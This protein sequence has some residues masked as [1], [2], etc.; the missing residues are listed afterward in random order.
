[1]KR[2]DLL[3]A[4]LASAML[5]AC[6]SNKPFETAP[7]PVA[8]TPPPA[9][10]AVIPPRK[11]RI[12]FALGGGAARGFAHVG[13]IKA[14]ETQGIVP[15]VVVGT[16]VGSVVGALYAAGG[17]AFALQKLAFQMEESA[18]TDWS[19]FDRGF[20]KGEALERFINQQ[21][22][23]RPIEQ[24][25]RRFG[26]VA[27]DLGRGEMTVFATGNVGQAVRASSA[28]PGVFGAVTIREREYVDGGLVSPIPVRAA[29]Q[30][31]ADIVIA[32]DISS[33]ASGRRQQ[34]NLDLMID[35]IAIMGRTI[36][37]YELKEADAVVRPDIVGLPVSNF[38]QRHEAIL[39]GEQAAYVALPRIRERIA[40][41][42]KQG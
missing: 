34:G 5:A 39:R 28:I 14:L 25:K 15:D 2:R 11:P 4:G 23:N 6:A 17:D 20:I 31:G 40:A 26:A 19:V 18:L 24:L 12:G 30:M 9:P 33:Q 22:G 16:S 32:V 41:F 27:T 42:G 21:V 10:V 35:T 3:G 37:N 1:M 13:V 8:V 38:Q 36:A 29:R 7:T